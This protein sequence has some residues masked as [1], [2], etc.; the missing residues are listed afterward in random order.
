[1]TTA[2]RRI[3]VAVDASPLSQAAV[4]AAV[5]LATRLDAEVDAVFVEDI[6]IVRLASH[7]YVHTFSLTAARRAA[8]D[9][10]LIEKALQ[11]QGVAARRSLEQASGDCVVKGSFTTRRGRVAAEIIAAAHGA[12]L[13]C[14]GWHGGPETSRQPPPLGQIART[15]WDAAPQPVLV[16]Q[17][18][19]GGPVMA[20]F[21]GSAA[22]RRALVAAA[23]LAN[24][25]GGVV[26]LL[27]PLTDVLA[28]AELELQAVDILAEY[29]VVGRHR[30][31]GPLSRCLTKAAADGILVAASEAGLP[32][33][34]LP[35]SMLVVR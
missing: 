33:D 20:L 26:E 24:Q 3:V 18:S 6:N 34:E 25:D 9:D 28:V 21:D 31:A 27:I 8:M 30:S 16:L 32:V 11:L 4:A 12:D 7:P 15:L 10:S 19:G 13:I 22:S 17:K 23:T 35:C 1:M 5:A 2:I 29:G 14:L